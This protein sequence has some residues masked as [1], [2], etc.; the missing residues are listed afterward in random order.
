MPNESTKWLYEQLTNK[1][2]NVG[3]NQ[4]EFDNLMSTNSES[5]K[6]AYDTAKNAGLNVGKDID[7]FTSLVAPQDVAIPEPSAEQQEPEQPTWE[8]TE[9]DKIRTTYQINR[10]LNDFNERSRER[11]AQAQR[12]SEPMT[13][14]GRKKRRVIQGQ[15]IGSPKKLPGIT[16]PAVTPASDGV[17][18]DAQQPTTQ[19]GQSPVPY[20]VKYVDGKPV[21]QWL[22]PDGRITTDIT[23]ADQ[24][25][26]G[27]RAVRLR[28]QFEDRMRQNGLNPEKEEDVVEQNINDALSINERK[29][30]EIYDRR[31]REFDESRDTQQR[32]GESKW[33]RF[34]HAFGSTVNSANQNMHP[35]PRG[36]Q[37]GISE[38][39]IK[40]DDVALE[41]LLAENQMLEEARKRLRASSGLKKSEGWLNGIFDF[42]NN[43]RNFMAG[44]KDKLTEADFYGGGIVKAQQADR[45]ISIEN[46]LKNNE[47][48][49]DTDLSLVYA[50]MLN[51]D[52]NRLA[53]TP[54]GY[55]AGQITTE[56]VP[57]M[58]QMA[59][60]PASGLSK[61][62]VK[63]FGTNRVKKLLATI[64]GD[65]TESAVLAN[66]LQ[67]P[68]T[69]G[70]IKTRYIGNAAKN[71]D[72]EIE[73]DGSHDWT[74]ATAKGQGAKLI[75]N[76]TEKLGEHFGGIGKFL[77]KTSTTVAKKAG[78]GK[79][80]ENVGEL[81]S[82][83]KANDW[84]KAIS[85]IERRAQWNGPIYEVL[86]EESGIVLNSLFVGDNSLSDLTD[87][88]Q[89][90]DI[91]LGVGLF[92]GFV[93]GIKT[94]GYPIARYK[95]KK[96]LHDADKNGQFRFASEWD[97][98][99]ETIDNADEQQLPNVVISLANEKAQSNE[100]AKSI[101]AYASALLKERGYNLAKASKR[102]EGMTTPEEDAVESSYDNGRELY[103]RFEQGDETAQPEVDATALRMQEAY[104]VFNDAFGAQSE[105]YMAR[106][107]D[108]QLT[109]EQRASAPWE[110]LEDPELTAEKKDA[111]LYYIN[112]KAALD[113][114]M[115]ASNEAADSKRKEVK[116]SVNMRTHRT[117]NVIIPAETVMG[118]QV[119]IVSGKVMMNPDGKGV[120]KTN[121]DDQFYIFN[122]ET[123]KYESSAPEF[124]DSVGE[125]VNPQDELDTA[126]SVIDHEQMSVF[127]ENAAAPEISENISGS[128]NDSVILPTDNGNY[129]DRPEQ[130]NDTASG[131]N[132]G[133]TL[134]PVVADATGS[135]APDRDR[136]A[137][138]GYEEGLANQHYD[139]TE[140]SERDRR[141]AESERLVGI[142]RANGQYF[143][144]EK[145]SSLGVRYPKW[146]G[147]SEVYISR[148]NRKIYKVKNPYAK[149]PLKGNVQPEDAIFEHLV[150]NKYFPETAYGF[151]GISDDTG[152]ARIILS[153][154]F[155]ESVGQ[156]TQEQI[157]KALGAK[158]LYPE[159]KYRYGNDEVSVTDVTGDNALLGADGN[160]YFI[161]P[162]I[163]FKKP[164]REILGE[165]AVAPAEEA[166][167][168]PESAETVPDSIENP[169]IGAE[170][171]ENFT[172]NVPKAAETVIEPQRSSLS[173]AAAPITALSRIPVGEEGEPKFEAV[174]R[175]TAWNGLVEA[176][177][178]EADAAEIAM[179]Q[180]QQASADLETLKKKP[181]TMKA[182]KLKGSPMAMAQAK[183]D[184]AEK[185]QAE[186]A[187]YNQQIADMQGRLDAWNGIIAV[188][189][190]RNAELERQQAEERR[191]QEAA[192]QAE[193]VARFEEQQRVKAEKE[194]EAERLGTHSVHPR[195]RERWDAAPK[196]EGNTDAI[197]LPD[198][199]ML[200]GRYI[201]TEAGAASASHDANNAYQPTE[202]F[203]VDEN[204][205]SVNDRDYMRDKDAQQLVEGMAGSYDNRA[206]QDPVIVSNDGVVLSGN[207]R[208]M[209]GDLAASRG[210]DK[211]YNDYLAQ[212]G[213]K[214]YGFTPEQ[215]NG[216]KNPRVVFVPDDTLPYDATTFAR[217]NAQEKKSQGKPEAAVK[218]GKIVPDDVFGGIV[219]EISRYDRLSDY[220][221][222]EKAVA[223]ALGALMQ[224]G[225]INDKQ[226]PELRTGT[227]LS[228]S[229][230]WPRRSVF[231]ILR[232]MGAGV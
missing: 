51:G 85:D 156:P 140:Y 170:N 26:Y 175:E 134:R 115:D 118:K 106:M 10:M 127:G 217:F 228:A 218:L 191:Q 42:R 131:P 12:V 64:A 98:I 80:V 55:N 95:A 224:A 230:T 185:Y 31:S 144:R 222:D 158:G 125:A 19:S 93:S 11:V 196:V 204:G 197:T 35:T 200:T 153:Q 126:L 100:Q 148:G 166:A 24:A 72:G 177:G 67:L 135:L 180:V 53:E 59:A 6:W 219:G 102:A 199:S 57:F 8:P 58:I 149:S 108:P 34:V 61:A 40:E 16:P 17:E 88:E 71:D 184:A 206:L 141:E 121:S 43:A 111:V 187:Q 216:M 160:V 73:F 75:E 79:V 226:L 97:G 113:G 65:V 76:Y 172:E 122:P 66:T 198:G 201:L 143:D 207:N 25:E 117:G 44:V 124:I 215:V 213:H 37:S 94:A 56:M 120:D 223:Q 221:A 212:F 129:G 211:A 69:I 179:A 142:A 109:E 189:N 208:T 9:Q 164:V 3:K 13:A 139:G 38:E 132:G 173:E 123:G 45:L 62:L 159:G 137:I 133:D 225:V 84:A 74:E 152:E 232:Y 46:K 194:A 203:P 145:K 2:Y 101:A 209:S 89:Q 183:R 39:H 110:L 227:A 165:N 114:V 15:V 214:K 157:A 181:P 29:I 182:P 63:K 105:Y 99:R 33:D 169:E 192:A 151:E 52:V 168:V 220:Y 27:A 90:I 174:D 54:H 77:G 119:Y 176:V 154:D 81:V 28:E 210:T 83:I 163:D 87:K 178:G 193:A 171:G 5:R 32:D 7:E 146:T 36:T 4:A 188:H 116:Q 68:S 18:G 47:Q 128:G 112:A 162:I 103:E 21:A 161:D 23:E 86:E 20:G 91:F 136:S 70:E 150:H 155:V 104:D 60:N 50:S 30:R 14:E 202:G 186:L 229:T 48:L 205:Q 78:L 49:T 147:E 92:G 1:G 190:S 41:N 138:R 195:I 231:A 107:E 82:Q 130:N 167:T 96:N 22:L